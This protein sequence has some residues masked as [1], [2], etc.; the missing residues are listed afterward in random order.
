MVFYPRDFHVPP[1]QCQQSLNRINIKSVANQSG[2]HAPHQCIWLNI[3]SYHSTRRHTG[4]VTNV[5]TIANNRP[6]TNPDVVS[7]DN[8]L[9]FNELIPVGKTQTRSIGL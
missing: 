3:L 1:L 5:N 8:S 2:R 9:R 7:D 4:S 6:L